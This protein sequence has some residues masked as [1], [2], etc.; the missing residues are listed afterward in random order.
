VTSSA[1]HD[2]LFYTFSTVAQTLAGALG[3]LF[4]A[5]LYGMQRIDSELSAL[6]PDVL[7]AAG[8]PQ[9]GDEGKGSP[10]NERWRAAEHHQWKRLRPLIEED[11]ERINTASYKL[12]RT[13]ALLVAR[14]WVNATFAWAIVSTTLTVIGVLLTLPWIPRLHAAWTPLI[15]ASSMA[16]LSFLLMVITGGA[17]FMPIAAKVEPPEPVVLDAEFLYPFHRP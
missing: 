16:A 11:R 4:A 2:A 7:R 9:R 14:Q 5:V 13:I 6:V 10:E 8:Y 12:E 3:F 17:I 1:W 15:V